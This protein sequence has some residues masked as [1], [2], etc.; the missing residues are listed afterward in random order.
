MNL[1]NR[2]S[3]L[4]RGALAALTLLTAIVTL[5]IGGNDIHLTR[6]AGDC[7]NLLPATGLLPLPAPASAPCEAKYTE[8][9]VN[10]LDRRIDETLINVD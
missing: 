9:G 7:V 5:T 6:V 2:N 1:A 8:N 3:R 4:V 10:E